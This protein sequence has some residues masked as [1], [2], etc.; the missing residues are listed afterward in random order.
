M[1][2]WPGTVVKAG[3]PLSSK[4]AVKQ[5]SGGRHLQLVQRAIKTIVPLW[6]QFHVDANADSVSSTVISLAYMY[7][8]NKGIMYSRQM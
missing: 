2:S 7:I 5:H 6:R 3:G 4:L 8:E 1:K